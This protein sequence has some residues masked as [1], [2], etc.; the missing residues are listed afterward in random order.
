MTTYKPNELRS[1]K[2][3]ITEPALFSSPTLKDFG[4]GR[5]I[6]ENWKIG[7][8]LLHFRTQNGRCVNMEITM[9]HEDR[10]QGIRMR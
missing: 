5:A 6:R 1:W 9:S 2:F 7:E 8:I 4:V 10:P 3:T